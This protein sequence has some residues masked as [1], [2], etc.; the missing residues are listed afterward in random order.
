MIRHVKNYY[1]VRLNFFM[2]LYIFFINLNFL[3]VQKWFVTIL[4]TL[5]ACV[6]LLIAIIKIST[7]ALLGNKQLFTNLVGQPDQ[8]LY[9]ST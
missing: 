3:L 7:K 5:N 9:Q 6:L 1:T 4:R 2:T 8:N